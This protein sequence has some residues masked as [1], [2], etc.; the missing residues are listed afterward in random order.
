MRYLTSKNTQN[1]RSIILI[2]ENRTQDSLNQEKPG[3]TG[4]LSDIINHYQIGMI[5]YEIILFLQFWV[6][7]K[8]LNES[9]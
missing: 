5:Q 8:I 7:W 4:A 6:Y 3:K 9:I 2:I 1:I